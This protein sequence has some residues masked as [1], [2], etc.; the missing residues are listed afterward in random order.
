MPE[1]D[2]HLLKTRIIRG[3]SE[4]LQDSNI[5]NKGVRMSIRNVLTVGAALMG[6]TLAATV[7]VA[8]DHVY[9]EGPVVNVAMIRT[10]DGKFEDYMNWLGTTWKQQQEAMKKAGYILS[11][12]VLTIEARSPQDPD[13]LLVTT[14]KNWAALD[15]SIAKGDEIAKQVEGSVAAA[16]K[17]QY[18]RAKIRTVLGS[19][20]AQ[21]LQ[22]K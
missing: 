16:A 22:L 9:T 12:E 15:G 2:R 10:V 21:V 19:S 13:I 8:D 18:E 20:T 14:Y 11:Y 4:F 17:S 7:A 1:A 6:L 5:K 3:S